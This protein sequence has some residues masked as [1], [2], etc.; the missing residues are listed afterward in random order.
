MD[1]YIE[2][3]SRINKGHDRNVNADDEADEGNEIYWEIGKYRVK[4]TARCVF[5]SDKGGP[6][7]PRAKPQ[8]MLTGVDGK[9]KKGVDKFLAFRNI[10]LASGS[11][12]HA[13]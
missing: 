10:R 6:Q 11:A 5:Y 2:M 1:G 8:R 12:Y 13:Y 9:S 3:Q 7:W 4:Q